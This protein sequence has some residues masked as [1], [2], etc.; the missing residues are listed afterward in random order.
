MNRRQ[1]RDTAP[2]PRVASAWSLALALAAAAPLAAC[3]SDPAPLP[4]DAIVIGS[5]LPFTGQEAA[6]GANLEQ[7]M[8]LAVEDVN[9]AG[10]VHGRPLALIS[11]DSNSGSA[12]GLDA[13]L[14]LLYV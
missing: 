8:L 5:L 9:A 13:L 10:G 3:G 7:A 12:R 6:L 11:R 1:V 4:A 14:E 2:C